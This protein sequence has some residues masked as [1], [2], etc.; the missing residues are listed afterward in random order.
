MSESY[1][2]CNLFS[3]YQI[4]SHQLN[5]VHLRSQLTEN[6][7]SSHD[8]KEGYDFIIPQMYVAAAAD[9]NSLD[10]IWFIKV[11]ETDCCGNGKDGDDYGN[12]IPVDV[13]FIKGHFKEKSVFSNFKYQT[14]KYSRKV[15]FFYKESVIY[16]Y[17]NF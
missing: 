1:G 14:Y 7:Y 4:R 3:S 13:N 8:D 12:I 2:S 11:L 16:P 17:I 6:V 9:D 15:T 5:K 10:P